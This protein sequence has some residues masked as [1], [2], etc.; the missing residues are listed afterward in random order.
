MHLC[1]HVTFQLAIIYIKYPQK[2]LPLVLLLIKNI[3]FPNMISPFS[4]NP[5]ILGAGITL[6]NESVVCL[7]C[8][9]T[10]SFR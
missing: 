10:H 3:Y 9:N 2:A 7:K 6:L 4:Y 5:E 1:A 8:M